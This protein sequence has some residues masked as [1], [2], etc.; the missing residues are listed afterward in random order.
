MTDPPTG[1]EAEKSRA[2]DNALQVRWWVAAATGL[3]GLLLGV[4]TA[5]LLLATTPQFGTSPDQQASR[6]P[7]QQPTSRSTVPVTAEARV[8]A[9]C[10]RVINEAQ[11]VV[12]ILSGADQAVTDVDLQRLDDIV[13]RLQPIETRLHKDLHACRVD[14]SVSGASTTSPTSTNPTTPQPSSTPS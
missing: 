14:T 4:L 9:A 2:P 10:L 1:E 6:D 3:A 5:A 12:R 11:D 8:N 7:N 13:R